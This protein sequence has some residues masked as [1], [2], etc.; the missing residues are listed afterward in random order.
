MSASKWRAHTLYRIKRRH[1][2]QLRVS[3]GKQRLRDK[4]IETRFFYQGC[5]TGG[6]VKVVVVVTRTLTASRLKRNSALVRCQLNRELRNHAVIISHET[7][8]SET[9]GVAELAI[10]SVSAL[11]STPGKQATLKLVLRGETYCLWQS[12][13]NGPRECAGSSRL[14]SALQKPVTTWCFR[15]GVDQ[16]VLHKSIR[17]VEHDHS[18]ALP[19]GCLRAR[20]RQSRNERLL[21]PHQQ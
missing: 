6:D 8:K 5:A 3:S 10:N 16:P 11:R 13:R 18:R 7:R 15:T 21:P 12:E 9:R 17:S 4:I 20:A 1:V 14:D 2:T 19:R